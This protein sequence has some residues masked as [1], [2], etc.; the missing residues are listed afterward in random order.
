MQA[1]TIAT[2]VV[3]TLK[4]AFAPRDAAIAELSLRVEQSE[5]TT[6][7]LLARLDAVEALRPIPGPPGTNGKDGRDGR[8]GVAGIDGA[9]LVYC[10]V[11][12]PDK[13]YV[14]GEFVTYQ[15]SLW[16]CNEPTTNRPGDGSRSWTLAV[17][18]PQR[19]REDGR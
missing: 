16:H 11:H 3:K 2:V 17:K 7:T 9:S 4:S 19:K 14:V 5:A 15:G 12:V 6:A 8:D 18:S 1:E 10:G 13:K